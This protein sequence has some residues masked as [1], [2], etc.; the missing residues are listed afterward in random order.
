M[1]T[2]GTMAQP[3][4]EKGWR[5]DDFWEGHLVIYTHHFRAVNCQQDEMPASL[6]A[7]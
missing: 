5:L 3:S 4:L 7:K 6:P 2:L 1:G